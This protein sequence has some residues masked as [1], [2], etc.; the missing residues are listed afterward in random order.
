MPLLI[1]ALLISLIF[2][3]GQYWMHRLMHNVYPLWL[4]HAPHHHVTQLNALL[5]SHLN[6]STS[7]HFCDSP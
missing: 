1:Q 7:T 6:A 2:D 4:T 5:R 3:F